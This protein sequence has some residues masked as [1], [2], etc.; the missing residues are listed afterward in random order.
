MTDIEEILRNP[1]SIDT[2]IEAAK[3]ERRKKYNRGHSTEPESILQSARIA[4]NPERRAKV[5]RAGKASKKTRM[6]SLY[7]WRNPPQYRNKTDEE[8]MEIIRK[9]N[10]RVAAEQTS[11][12]DQD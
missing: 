4:Q 2:D 5:V 6:A 7:T 1:T 11:T 9:Y 8:L 12:P 3:K 10:E